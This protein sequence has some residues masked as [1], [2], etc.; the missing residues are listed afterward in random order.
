MIKVGDQVIITRVDAT[1]ALM[2]VRADTICDVISRCSSML[3]LMPISG[4]AR[5]LYVYPD[6]V[7]KF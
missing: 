5:P 7:R 4:R 6:Q 1:D 2:G 3:T